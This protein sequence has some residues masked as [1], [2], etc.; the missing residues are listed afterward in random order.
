M[1]YGDPRR[2]SRPPSPPSTRPGCTSTS[3]TDHAPG[4]RHRRRPHGT[5]AP[6]R[7]RPELL[8]QQLPR[9]RRPPRGR[10]RR[11]RRLGR[12]GFG[13]ASVRFICGTQSCTATGG[14]IARFLGTDDTILYS[15]CFDAN[16]GVFE[17]LSAP[18]TRSSPTSSTTPRSSTASGSARRD[19]IRYRNATSP[20]CEARLRAADTRRGPFA[21]SSSPT[22][23]SRW[24]APSPPGRDLRSG[25][26][27]RRAGDGRRQPRGRLR[28]PA[29]GRGTPELFGVA[30]RVDMLSGTLGKALG[31]ASGGY[32]SGRRE[33]IA[34]LRQR[35]RPYLF[36]NAV[37]PRSPPARC[38]RSHR[39]HL[40]RP[41]ASAAERLRRAVPRL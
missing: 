14:A 1:T 17:V 10:R 6:G 13:M 4:A 12:W 16:G 11:P 35:A 20:T 28:R 23:S 9:P 24:T 32:V 15:S 19:A 27:V 41:C 22:A 26:G 38:R 8:R 40:G 7:R 30:G 34:L 29:T 5:A 25:G 39:G 37:A 2:T 3:A 36:S 33:V 21:S 18:R 31:G